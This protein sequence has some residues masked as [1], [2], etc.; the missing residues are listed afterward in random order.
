MPTGGKLVLADC[1]TL[2][3][4]FIHHGPNIHHVPFILPW[5]NQSRV[6]WPW[7][8]NLHSKYFAPSKYRVVSKYHVVP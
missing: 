7:A 4:P 1:G 2:T 8:T 3:C 5:P 6:K